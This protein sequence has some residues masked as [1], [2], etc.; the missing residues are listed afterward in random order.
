MPGGWGKAPLEKPRLLQNC[1]F[2]TLLQRITL[3]LRTEKGDR[4]TARK[5]HSWCGL[6]NQGR[7]PV[8]FFLA[9]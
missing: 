4:Q 8:P 3:A 7:E 9:L 6:L 5:L 2:K 1:D